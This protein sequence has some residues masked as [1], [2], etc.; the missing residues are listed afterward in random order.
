[1]VLKPC[2]VTGLDQPIIPCSAR[3]GESR[4]VFLQQGLLTH[5]GKPKLR[6]LELGFGTGLKCFP[7][8]SLFYKKQGA[9]FLFRH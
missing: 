8:L 1:M 9:A 6:V 7:R 4:H 3:S 5:T 2:L